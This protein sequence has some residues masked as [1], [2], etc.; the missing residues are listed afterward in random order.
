MIMKGWN[1]EDWVRSHVFSFF[2]WNRTMHAGIPPGAF[3][4]PAL[5]CPSSKRNAY[6]IFLW[7]SLHTLLFLYYGVGIRIILTSNF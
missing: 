5:E 2:L 4:T 6:N 3:D 1:S 7:H